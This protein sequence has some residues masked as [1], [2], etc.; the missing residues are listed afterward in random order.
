MIDSHA[1]LQ[2]DEFNDDRDEI[3]KNAKEAG[4]SAVIAIG[5]S[6]SDSERAAELAGL[7][8][9]VYASAGVHPHEVKDMG[10]STY[11]SLRLLTRRDKVVAIGEIGLDFYYNHSSREQQFQRFADQLDMAV[12]LGLPVIIHDREAHRETIEF[13]AY[14]KGRLRGV[15]HCF[16]G[17][18]GMARK[19]VDLGFHIS[20]A[21]PVTYK[22][23]EQLQRVAAD[24]PLEW[25]LVETDSPYL[26]PQPWRGK[27]NEPAYV[28]A[29]ARRIAEIRG[30]TAEE[31]EA[32]TDLNTRRL[33]GF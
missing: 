4:L 6:L 8:D 17:D 14:R 13:L 31:L 1:H 5:T 2:M 7:Y 30:I 28:V 23:S 15:L 18:T 33:F 9:C 22:K 10:V 25:M 16:S 24:I 12:E 20:I 29:T 21:G 32:A 26:A 27:R 3:V 19:C 11:D